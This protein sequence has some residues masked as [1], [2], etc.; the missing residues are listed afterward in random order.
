MAF[1]TVGCLSYRTAKA[2]VDS[3]H[4][5]VE[6]AVHY[7]ISLW[8]FQI[9]DESEML[10]GKLDLLSNTNMVDFA[11]DVYQ[12]LYPDQEVPQSMYWLICDAY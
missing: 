8:L 10:K 4:A 2:P 5:L 1:V 11:M 3:K 9:Y 12:N 6:K 7:L